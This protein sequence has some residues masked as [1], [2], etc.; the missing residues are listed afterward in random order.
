MEDFDYGKLPIGSVHVVAASTS[1][2]VVSL[3]CQ[4]QWS[5]SGANSSGQ[6]LAPTPVD[7][8]WRQLQ[9]SVLGANSSGQSLAPTPVVSPWR[10]LQWSVLGANS[11]GQSLA[12]TSSCF[13]TRRHLSSCQG[14]TTHCTPTGSPSEPTIIYRKIREK[15]KY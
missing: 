5:V 3:W 12:P 13:M 8:P 4:L 15:K 7:S 14:S 2:P 10:Q 9:W 11:S 1:S 6:S